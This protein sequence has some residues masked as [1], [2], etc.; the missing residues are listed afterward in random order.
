MALFFRK[1]EVKKVKM[2][3]RSSVALM[4]PRRKMVLF[5]SEGDGI[6]TVKYQTFQRIDKISKLPA[7]KQVTGTIGRACRNEPIKKDNKIVMISRTHTI[8]SSSWSPNPSAASFQ[9]SPSPPVP[10]T[11]AASLRRP[12]LLRRLKQRVSGESTNSRSCHVSSVFPTLSQLLP[13]AV[14]HFSGGFPSPSRFQ[15]RPPSPFLI[16]GGLPWFFQPHRATT[17]RIV[18]GFF[19]EAAVCAPNITTVSPSPSYRTDSTRT[20]AILFLDTTVNSLWFPGIVVHAF[21][22]TRP[23]PATLTMM[24]VPCVAVPEHPTVC[25]LDF[26]F[27]NY[28]HFRTVAQMPAVLRDSYLLRTFEFEARTFTVVRLSYGLSAVSFTFCL[29]CPLKWPNRDNRAGC[30]GLTETRVVTVKIIVNRTNELLSRNQ[31]HCLVNMLY[32]LGIYIDCSLSMGL[33]VGN[34]V[35][36]R[37]VVCWDFRRSL[38]RSVR[39]PLPLRLHLNGVQIE[40]SFSLHSTDIVRTSTDKGR[41]KARSYTL[42]QFRIFICYASALLNN[43]Y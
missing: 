40:V 38:R 5:L 15:P 16:S 35:S 1:I 39:E 11:A 19:L 12:L 7:I 8:S 27:R 13:A 17:A 43:K 25:R 4:K 10:A 34:R 6:S 29:I 30:P 21:R 36:N 14:L 22:R 37:P 9:P 28:S 42:L 18:A 26:R 20:A 24:A 32:F 31:L 33:R 2:R 41:A 3:M 23:P